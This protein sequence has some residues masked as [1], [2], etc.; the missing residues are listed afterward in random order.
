MGWIMFQGLEHYE[1]YL[2][3]KNS[4]LANEIFKYLKQSAVPSLGLTWMEHVLQPHSDIYNCTSILF[5]TKYRYG[6]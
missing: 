2:N 6:I 5:N 1:E 4:N 3:N